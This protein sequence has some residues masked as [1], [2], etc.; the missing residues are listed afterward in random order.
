[1]RMLLVEDKAEFAQDIERAVR[2]LADCELVWAESRDSALAKLRAEHFDLVVLDRNIPTQDGF[3][4]DHQDHGWVVF[5]HIRDQ[6]P[7][8]P[9]WFLTGT[10]DNDFAT[11]INNDYGRTGDLHG[12]EKPEPLYLVCC[13]RK[14]S[15]C[16]RRIKEF[17]EKREQLRRIAVHLDAGAVALKPEE[18]NVIQLFGRR[19]NGS[20]VDLDS[21]NGGLSRSR[22][23]KVIV[24][25][26]NSGAL[27]TAAAKVSPL[28]DIRDEAQRYR[29]DIARLTPGGFPQLSV[30]I[31]VGAG[32]Y[33]GLFY[34]MVG[35]SVESLFARIASGHANI[36]A[37]PG[38]LRAIEAPWHQTKRVENVQVA[39]I[40]R[41]LIGDA[42]L[43]AVRG[44]LDGIDIQAIEN[45]IVRAGQCC[46]H[47]DL[48][49]ANVVFAERGQ[50]MLI[51]FGDTGASFSALDPVTLE[52]STI[53][54]S[55]HKTLP[56]GWPTE[57]NLK[58]WDKPE[59]FA[60]GCS[61]GRFIGACREWALADGASSEE[62]ASIAYA[63]AMR[64]LKYDD[65]D[66]DKARA[67]I[68]SC[69]KLLV[70]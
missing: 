26:G 52:L 1:M 4:D 15:D 17:A 29:N 19:Y 68:R 50:A 57:Q 37:I 25:D 12:H 2:G 70:K 51:D 6:L 58:N 66:K 49:C 48:H 31:D 41:K 21:L 24:R 64:Q 54:H 8:T 34:G 46:Q 16:V 65:T 62:V 35:D 59:Q 7:G 61:F 10:E 43:Q 38:D 30:M 56:A 23:L 27:I 63:Y 36:E 60:E 11:D 42:A 28:Q 33:G 22:V 47:G 69:I 53:F 5:Q 45:A 14:V 13:K 67:L 40:R 18:L 9:V 20:A 39:Q 44:E 32:A 3:L 55:Q